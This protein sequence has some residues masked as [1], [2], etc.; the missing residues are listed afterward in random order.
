MVDRG[1]P[2]LKR[3]VSFAARSVGGRGANVARRY[4]R[5]RR[6]RQQMAVVAVVVGGENDEEGGGG[7]GSVVD[8]LLQQ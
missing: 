3:R 8:I 4:R 1:V 7:R 6:E 5:G 2:R